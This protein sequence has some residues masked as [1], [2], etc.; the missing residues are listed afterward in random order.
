MSNRVKLLSQVYAE[1]YSKNT[2][3]SVRDTSREMGFSLVGKP[4]RAQFSQLSSELKVLT[5]SPGYSKKLLEIPEKY[6][7]ARVCGIQTHN[8]LPHV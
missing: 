7:H 1:K 4:Q 8:L 3:L 5:F 2:S 6:V